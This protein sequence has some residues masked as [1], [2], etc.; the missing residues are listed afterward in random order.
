MPG[1][2]ENVFYS[3]TDRGP[4]VDR[5]ESTAKTFPQPDF[6]P[7]IQRIE[8]GRDNTFRVA[9]MINIRDAEGSPIT[10]LPNPLKSTRTELAYDQAGARLP[11]DPNGLDTEGLVR[12]SDGTFW[13]ADEYAPSLVHVASNGRI[14]E[15]LVPYGIEGDLAK[16]GYRIRAALPAILARRHLN[17]GFEGI[18]VSPDEA[19]LYAMMQNPLANPDVATYKHAKATRLF[20]IETATGKL[21]GEYVYEL[22][23]YQAFTD[24]HDANKQSDVRI[25]ELS[26]FA[27]DKLVVL[28]RVTHTTILYAVNLASGSNILGTEWDDAS[29]VPTLEQVS[30]AGVGIKPLAKVKWLDS[31]ERDD[32]PSKIEG[33]A[34]IPPDTLVIINDNDFGIEGAETKILRLMLPMPL[35]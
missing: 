27:A 7:S 28:E 34:I 18:A 17:R 35:V 5:D 26:A 20:K 1:D 13:L 33:V 21:V 22:E 25:S 8:L 11:F 4:N 12:L 32:I 23:P 16:A 14:I 2:P 6:V 15:R 9:W 10:G 30:L 3:V 24:D 31:T 19:F 29:T